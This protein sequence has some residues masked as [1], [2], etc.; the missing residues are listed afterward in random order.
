MMNRKKLGR[1]LC[2]P[3]RDANLIFAWKVMQQEKTSVSMSGATAKI[4]T[5]QHSKLSLQTCRHTKL[6]GE[7]IS[8][9]MIFGSAL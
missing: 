6:F 8:K 9:C 2:C 3:S 1:K 7:L 5:R 4:Q